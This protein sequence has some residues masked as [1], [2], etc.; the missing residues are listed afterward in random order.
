MEWWKMLKSVNKNQRYRKEW[1]NLNQN[2]AVAIDSFMVARKW[3]ILTVKF[4]QF[5][6]VNIFKFGRVDNVL[7]DIWSCLVT[8]H[9]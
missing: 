7:S 8:T 1:L 2:S 9:V 3:S 5:C 4:V 6:A